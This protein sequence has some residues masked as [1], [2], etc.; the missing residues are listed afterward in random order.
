MTQRQ[1]RRL[2]DERPTIQFGST[3]FNNAAYDDLQNILLNQKADIAR[4][5]NVEN[6]VDAKA[7][8][9]KHRLRVPRPNAQ[10]ASGNPIYDINN[11]GIDDIILYN[12][13]GQ[14]VIVNGYKLKPSKAPIRQAYQK[15]VPK[16]ERA[17][18]PM[19]KY[20]EQDVYQ[21]ERDENGNLTN[22][23]A[24]PE[25]IQQLVSHGWRAPAKPSKGP[26]M[27]NRLMS[28]IKQWY[29]NEWEVTYKNFSYAKNK[30][31][32]WMKVCSTVYK[33]IVEKPLM[34]QLGFE[35]NYVGWEEFKKTNTG[36]GA[37]ANKF[38][39]L[40]ILNNDEFDQ[41]VSIT[42]AG[43]LQECFESSRLVDDDA[44]NQ[45]S[46]R[47]KTEIINDGKRIVDETLNACLINEGI[48]TKE[49]LEAS[50]KEQKVNTGKQV[51]N[52]QLEGDY[53]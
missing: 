20:I 36:K 35:G 48:P 33:M 34:I 40:N 51:Y 29:D 26:S 46:R 31:F 5:P 1:I 47:Q 18:K 41:N 12:R 2:R 24:N 53:V 52:Y 28:H 25:L 38:A 14:P 13:A 21:A 15:A 49:Q 4:V 45:A 50:I 37:I 7:Y 43:L 9:E 44:F 17:Y 11:D 3:G 22:Y 32:S 27:Y 39:E 6:W 8:A 23:N 42:M 16:T 19:R 10:D 30:I